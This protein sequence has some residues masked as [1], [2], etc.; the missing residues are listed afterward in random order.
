MLRT[1]ALAVPLGLMA[2]VGTFGLNFQVVLPLLAR[3]SFDGDAGTYALL[4]SAMGAGSVAGALLTA[5]AGRAGPQM[6]TGAAAGFGLAAL[7]AAAAPGVAFDDP[8]AGRPR[9]RW[10]DLRG[11]RQLRPAARG[12]SR[13]CAA[14]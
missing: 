2:I 8:G 5:G 6:L 1:P 9:G 7:L 10:R 3:F 4:V 13:T 14:G 11:H 12:R